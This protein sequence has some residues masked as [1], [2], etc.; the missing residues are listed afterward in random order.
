MER[1]RERIVAGPWFPRAPKPVGAA[2]FRNVE[3]QKKEGY[4]DLEAAW[5]KAIVEVH[6][7]SPEAKKKAEQLG[8]QL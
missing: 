6:G 4:I 2:F 7:D 8:V 3:L 5:A 1:S